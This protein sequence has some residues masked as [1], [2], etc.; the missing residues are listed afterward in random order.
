MSVTT[1]IEKDRTPNVEAI[2]E[3]VAALRSGKFMQ[4]TGRLVRKVD[5]APRY[6]CLGV[7]CEVFSE[8]LGIRAIFDP[9][10]HYISDDNPNVGKE[11]LMYGVLPTVVADH[12]G[13]ARSPIVRATVPI[14]TESA[15]VTLNDGFSWTFTQIADAI[16]ATYL[17]EET[18]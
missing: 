17:K 14:G 6:C 12:L 11:T 5:G 10:G 7:A 13:L 8:R 15:L 18:A 3:W 1:F 9:T 16:E 2:R 4:G